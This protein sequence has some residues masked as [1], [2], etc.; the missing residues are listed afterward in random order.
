MSNYFRYLGYGVGAYSAYDIDKKRINGDINW[1]EWSIEQSSNAFSTL[2]GQIG[3]AWSIGWQTG[4]AV[5][6]TEWYQETKFNLFY[7]LWE[8]KYGKPSSSNEW[9][10]NYFYQNYKP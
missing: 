6:N 5:T 1:T 3:A 2:G 8:R 9:I 4:R 7:D 10:W